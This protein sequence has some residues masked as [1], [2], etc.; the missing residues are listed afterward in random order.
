[1]RKQSKRKEARKVET[2][3]GEFQNKK[4][5]VQKEDEKQTNVAFKRNED[6]ITPPPLTPKSNKASTYKNPTPSHAR[7]S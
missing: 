6:A 5:N 1:M 3:G 2:N 7:P 4:K